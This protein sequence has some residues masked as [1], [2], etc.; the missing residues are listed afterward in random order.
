M[1]IITSKLSKYKS[2]DPCNLDMFNFMPQGHFNKTWTSK[3]G[4]VQKIT[5]METMHLWHIFRMLLRKLNG[6]YTEIV[7]NA[8][9]Y[10]GY[11]LYRRHMNVPELPSRDYKK[12][13]NRADNL[14]KGFI[15]LDDIGVCWNNGEFYK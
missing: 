10:I 7:S 3:D 4:T 6:P 15:D 12:H 2:K 8:F 5:E 11:E 9:Q 14:N 1:T 13:I